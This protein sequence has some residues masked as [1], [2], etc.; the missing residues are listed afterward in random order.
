MNH[1]E[2]IASIYLSNEPARRYSGACIVQI[3]QRTVAPGREGGREIGREGGIPCG[4]RSA[5][6]H[7]RARERVKESARS[8]LMSAMRV[9]LTQ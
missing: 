6:A 7:L 8:I 1:T 4:S 2:A 3:G 9:H 5:M